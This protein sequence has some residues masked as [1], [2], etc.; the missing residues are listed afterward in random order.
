[1]KAEVE[2]PRWR[3]KPKMAGGKPKMAGG[4]LKDSKALGLASYRDLLRHLQ[5]IHMGPSV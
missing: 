3:W 1:M 2:N 5:R 4:K